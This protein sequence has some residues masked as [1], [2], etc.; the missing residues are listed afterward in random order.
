[1]ETSEYFVRTLAS[2]VIEQSAFDLVATYRIALFSGMFDERLQEK[3]KFNKERLSRYSGLATYSVILDC[4]RFFRGRD[5][6]FYRN[7]L[8][9]VSTD[10]EKMIKKIFTKAINDTIQKALDDLFIS[11]VWLIKKGMM[12][13]TFEVTDKL[14]DTRRELAIKSKNNTDDK[15][16][17]KINRLIS[18]SI[19]KINIIKK[20]SHFL[21]THYTSKWVLV[22]S[23]VLYR[24]SADKLIADVKECVLKEIH[25]KSK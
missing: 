6:V 11:Y 9:G 5:Y 13:E 10:G 15:T 23:G 22:N 25:K 14:A 19:K 16:I 12:S 24:S 21:H 20:N 8:S 2:K 18:N 4:E 3:E 7:C 17:K 1:M